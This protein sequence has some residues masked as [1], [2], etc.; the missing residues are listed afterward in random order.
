[1]IKRN[2]VSLSNNIWLSVKIRKLKQVFFLSIEA[3][4]FS[5]SF[6]DS[7][8]ALVMGDEEHLLPD[9]SYDNSNNPSKDNQLLQLSF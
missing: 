1:M 2:R 9:A 6:P 3:N 5:R 4:K 7:H 8:M